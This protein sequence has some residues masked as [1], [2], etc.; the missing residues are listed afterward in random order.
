[1]RSIA[2]MSSRSTP[3]REQLARNRLIAC[4]CRT[5]S[6]SGIPPAFSRRRVTLP[7][8]VS[9]WSVSSRISGPFGRPLCKLCARVDEHETGLCKLCGLSD[10]RW[11]TAPVAGNFSQMSRGTALITGAGSGFGL[12]SAV[13]LARR[14]FRVLATL[15]DPSRSQKLD[16]AAGAAGVT[17]NKLQL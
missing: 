11:M 4:R 6:E 14:G 10:F 1:A 12:L 3:H 5:A 8:N 17:L 16:E 7:S 2:T 13:E 9:N 15:R